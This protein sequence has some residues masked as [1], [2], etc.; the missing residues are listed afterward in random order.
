MSKTKEE[1]LREMEEAKAKLN[2]IEEEEIKK[3]IAKEAKLKAS[4]AK[5]EAK[6]RAEE[7]RIKATV[8]TEDQYITKAAAAI[9]VRKQAKIAF[10]LAIVGIG[11]IFV[12][13]IA[14]TF[15]MYAGIV[16]AVIG[17]VILGYFG[18]KANL[19]VKYLN[20]TYKL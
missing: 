8:P 16:V 13:S 18:V 20:S 9:E 1:L 3:A 12:V 10:N 19:K 6:I 4:E 7:E 5:I 14:T 11:L 17:A 2:Y 15:S